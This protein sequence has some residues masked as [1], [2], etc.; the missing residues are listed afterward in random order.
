MLTTLCMCS[1]GMATM[2]GDA[3]PSGGTAEQVFEGLAGPVGLE[4]AQDGRM[5]ISFTGPPVAPGAGGLGYFYP[6]HSS[7]EID[8]VIENYPNA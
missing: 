1:L 6:F 4:F 5:W 3:P 7:P 2:L 8:V